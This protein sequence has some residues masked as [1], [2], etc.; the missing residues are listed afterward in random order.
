MIVAIIIFIVIIIADRVML[1]NICII[2]AKPPDEG[3]A[4]DGPFGLYREVGLISE[5]FFSNFSSK[6]ILS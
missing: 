1:F 2:L 4:R 6:P 3:Q 5:F